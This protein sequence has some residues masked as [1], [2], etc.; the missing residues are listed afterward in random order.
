L[1]LAHN[2]QKLANILQNLSNRINPHVFSSWFQEVEFEE[3]DNNTLKLKAKSKFYADYINLR[4]S[5]EIIEASKDADAN[6]K[7]IEIYTLSD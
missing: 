1:E 5:K 2:N 6:F 4:F 7:N 3:L